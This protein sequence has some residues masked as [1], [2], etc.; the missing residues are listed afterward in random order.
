LVL[1]AV[2]DRKATSRRFAGAPVVHHID[3]MA[4]S[5]HAVLTAPHARLWRDG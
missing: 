1:A 2:I 5:K 4:P 3:L